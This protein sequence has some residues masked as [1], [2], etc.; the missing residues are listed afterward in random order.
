MIS[1]AH[2]GDIFLSE[3][4]STR[5]TEKKRKYNINC[6]WITI[7]KIHYTLQQIID[8]IKCIYF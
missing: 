4:N 7:Y 3:D 6:M 5:I 1:N 2:K 8:H